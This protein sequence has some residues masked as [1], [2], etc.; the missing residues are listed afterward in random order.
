MS[1]LWLENNIRTSHY[2]KDFVRFARLTRVYNKRIMVNM[3]LNV[4][5]DDG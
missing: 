2:G 4:P 5:L 1:C 3:D